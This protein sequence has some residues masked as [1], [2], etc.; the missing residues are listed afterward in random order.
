M[1]CKDCE[2]LRSEIISLDS[3]DLGIRAL[4]CTKF[5]TG[6]RENMKLH[7]VKYT[8]PSEIIDFVKVFEC[9][10]KYNWI[11]KPLITNNVELP[12]W[13]PLNQII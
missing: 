9:D 5:E 4:K 2:F 12:Y 1:V 3:L 7:S 11:V 13:C 8:G 6:L 10:E